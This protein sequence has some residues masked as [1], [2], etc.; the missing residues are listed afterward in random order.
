MLLLVCTCN[1]NRSPLQ[2]AKMPG[3]GVPN[4]QSSESGP[5]CQLA[6]MPVHV[7]IAFDFVLQILV[8]MG[9][10][11]PNKVDVTLS[12][13]QLS[14]N[15]SIMFFSIGNEKPTINILSVGGGAGML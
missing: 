8:L 15:V 4:K 13:R 11:V 6:G 10:Q 14:Q 1:K 3:T 12:T 5:S 2:I 7:H 9:S